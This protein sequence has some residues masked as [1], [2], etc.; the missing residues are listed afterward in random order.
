MTKK[1]M[2]EILDLR[3]LYGGYFICNCKIKDSKY[4]KYFMEYL[5]KIDIDYVGTGGCDWEA[6]LFI[7]VFDEEK[8]E[9]VWQQVSF[10]LLQDFTI[11]FESFGV[12]GYEQDHNKINSKKDYLYLDDDMT[13]ELI[14][15]D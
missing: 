15:D 2:I 8:R 10:E 5:G 3:N 6:R 4:S 9:L 13:I 14:E 11:L 12:L 7:Y 1:Q